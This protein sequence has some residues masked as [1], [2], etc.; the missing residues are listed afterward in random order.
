MCGGRE[1]HFVFGPWKV[2]AKSNHILQSQ[3]PTPSVCIKALEDETGGDSQICMLC[4]YIKELK[5]PCHPDMTFAS[6]ILRL[7][8][9]SGCGMEFTCL[10]ALR[11]LSSENYVP[12]VA[13]AQAWQEARSDTDCPKEVVNPFDWTYTTDYRGTFLSTGKEIQVRDTTERIDMEKLKVREQIV[14]YQDICLYEDELADHGIAQCSVKMRIMKN[15]FFI[16]LRYFLRIDNVLIRMNDTRIY[17]EAGW[18]YLLREYTS[19]EAKANQ[20]DVPVS[21]LTNPAAL[22]EHLPVKSVHLEK[23]VL[24]AS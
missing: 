15:N 5:L 22:S 7:E 3:C 10:D 17:H 9:T 1:D 18:D 6:N 13:I 8:H 24:P 2:F 4:R 19:K 11:C 14:F 20:L 16:L 12:K 23:L 21:V